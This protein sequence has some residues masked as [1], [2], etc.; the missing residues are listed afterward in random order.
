M[1]RA[2]RIQPVVAESKPDCDSI[3]IAC[4]VCDENKAG[5]CSVV[6]KNVPKLKMSAIDWPKE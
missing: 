4:V 3:S 6:N 2:K 5:F 1:A